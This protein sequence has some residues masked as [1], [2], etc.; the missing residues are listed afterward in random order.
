MRRVLT[1]SGTID[2]DASCFELGFHGTSQS[3]PSSHAQSQAA[4]SHSCG[5]DAWHQPAHVAQQNSGVWPPA[6]EVRITCLL[7]HRTSM[8]CK[9]I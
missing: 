6:Q 7:R 8:R 5:R 3:L 9:V 4:A 2:L 1:L